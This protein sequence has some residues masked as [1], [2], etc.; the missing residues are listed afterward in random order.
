MTRTRF[1]QIRGALTLHPLEHPTFDKKRNPLWQFAVPISVSNIDEV[2]VRTKARTRARTF[3]PTKPDKYD[4]RFLKLTD[5]EMQLLGAVRI[6]LVD[7][8]NNPA[9]S[10]AI[11]GI[12]G[13]PRGGWEPVAT[14]D[15][16]PG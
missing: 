9:V 2:T 8:C 7:K 6:N 12:D 11:T 16:E 1:Q 10:A 3:T 5:G 14:V 4:V 13:G 15:P